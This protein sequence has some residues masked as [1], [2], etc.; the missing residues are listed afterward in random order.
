MISVIGHEGYVRGPRAVSWAAAVLQDGDVLINPITG[1]TAPSTSLTD[2]CTERLITRLPKPIKISDKYR[3]KPLLVVIIQRKAE[4]VEYVTMDTGR[5]GG[6]ID[7]YTDENNTYYVLTGRNSFRQYCEQVI[8]KLVDSISDDLPKLNDRQQEKDTRD[9]LLKLGLTLDSAHPIINALHVHF[10]SLPQHAATLARAR[11]RE[12]NDL[13]KFELMLHALKHDTKYGHAYSLKYEHGIVDGGGMDIDILTQLLSQ[14]AIVHRKVFPAIVGQFSFLRNCAPS[15]LPRMNALIPASAEIKFTSVVEKE[16]LKQRITRYLELYHLQQLVLGENSAISNYDPEIERALEIICNPGPGTVLSHRRLGSNDLESIQWESQEPLNLASQES[17]N[18]FGI[19]GF[20]SGLI[21]DS[22]KIEIK[23]APG[24]SILV[25]AHDNGF[26]VA[27]QGIDL[28]A[29]Q[30]YRPALYQVTRTITKRRVQYYLSS[31]QLIETNKEYKIESLPSSVIEGAFRRNLNIAV[32]WTEDG[33]QMLVNGQPVSFPKDHNKHSAESWIERVSEIG[34]RIELTDSKY[35]PEDWIRP[36][37]PPKTGELQRLL[38]V[39]DSQPENAEEAEV[40]EE[41][42][43]RFSIY[44]RNNNTRR[45]AK[46]H[47][48]LIG[49]DDVKHTYRLTGMGRSY[50]NIYR[51]LG[52]LE[53]SS[54]VSIMD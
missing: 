49:Y 48:E 24:A 15:L 3:S 19:L 23:I 2:L 30:L 44:A 34:R 26:G 53:N 27:P 39:L 38:I 6:L 41:I 13:E 29:K 35:K 11:L 17:Q 50:L 33:Q 28:A 32:T 12:K 1:Q 25:S 9:Q 8:T 45:T 37:K 16:T 7:S 43:E 20:Q 18:L 40:I 5:F 51:G 47:P 36:V 21:K 22:S 10:S 46:K 42:N 4:H 14:L 54:S 52:G 31:V